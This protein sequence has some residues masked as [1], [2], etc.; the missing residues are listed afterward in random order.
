MKK[1]LIIRYSD[2]IKYNKRF[3][4]YNEVE[5]NPITQNFLE[6]QVTWYAVKGKPHVSRQYQLW[7]YPQGWL[8][9]ITNLKLFD[10]AY[11]NWLCRWDEEGQFEIRAGIR[12]QKSLLGIMS[13]EEEKND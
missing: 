3:N 5:W 1:Q 8:Q 10:E 7:P 2:F 4:K 13:Y 9:R 6:K 11:R 12:L